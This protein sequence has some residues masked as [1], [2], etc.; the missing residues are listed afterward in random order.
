[1]LIAIPELLLERNTPS[2]SNCQVDDSMQQHTLDQL[3]GTDLLRKAGQLYTH[4]LADALGGIDPKLFQQALNFLALAGRVVVWCPGLALLPN[5]ACTGKKVTC[6]NNLADFESELAQLHDRD[7]CL[8]VVLPGHEFDA[9]S[10]SELARERG[11]VVIGVASKPNGPLAGIADVLLVPR[12]GSAS[13]DNTQIVAF[14]WLLYC[15]A[16]ALAL[17]LCSWNRVA[18]VQ[19]RESNGQNSGHPPGR[20]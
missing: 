3:D 16:D 17:G 11:V 18:Q 9:A 20:T 19:S 5:L 12:L 8:F 6:T 4:G 15:V 14:P 7:V 2:K 13:C 10:G 1:M